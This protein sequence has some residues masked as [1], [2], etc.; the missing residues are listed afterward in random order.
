MKKLV[1]LLL[2]IP[3]IS[4]FLTGCTA[5]RI[6][7]SDID[8]I[9]NVVLSKDNVLYNHI[10]KGYKYYIPRGVTY[11]DT[12][13]FNDKLYSDGDYYY[14]YIDA[15]SYYHQKE[16]KH[17][18]SNDSYYYKE[19]NIDNKKGY[20]EIKKIE[21]KYLIEFM[22]NY[23]R[24]ETQVDEEKINSV[25]LNSSY[26]LSTVKF[27]NNVIRIMLDE[28]YFKYKEEKFELFENDEQKENFLEY[29]E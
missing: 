16:V 3:V 21:D 12:V 18:K 11:I 5:V 25:I 28:D 9:V 13:E 4:I 27:N 1:S 29:S 7:T 22:Y 24:I 2:L 8:N 17:N 23:A 15:I 14:L 20:I 10:G 19:I 26:I 6:D